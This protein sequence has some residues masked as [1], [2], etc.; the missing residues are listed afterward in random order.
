MWHVLEGGFSQQH[1][2]SAAVGFKLSSQSAASLQN[3]QSLI[4]H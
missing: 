4:E 1:A 2:N 3:I